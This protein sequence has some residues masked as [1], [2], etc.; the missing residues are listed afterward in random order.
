[1]E[2]TLVASRSKKH[3]KK[4]DR[5]LLL[6][7]SVFLLNQEELSKQFWTV[8]NVQYN[9]TTQVVSIGISTTNGKLG[10][11]LAK[12]RKTSK[13]VSEYL[14]AHGLTFRKTQIVFYVEKEDV[15]IE[16]IYNIL[17]HIES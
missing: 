16:R 8:K 14:Y 3:Y 1:M 11:T 2:K 4:A 10:T 5:E 9:K 12:L 17:S 13:R 6:T 15:E 7:V